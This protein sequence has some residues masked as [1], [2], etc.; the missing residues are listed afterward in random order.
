MSLVPDNQPY[1]ALV[2]GATGNVGGS[3]VQLLIQNPLCRKVILA[4]R[5][6]TNAFPSPKVSE[7]VVNMDHLEQELA[8]HANGVAVALAAFG[9]GKGSARMPVEEVR[10]IEIAYPLAFCRAAKSGGARVCALMSA[11][12]ANPKSRAT[13]ART[14]GEKEQA[15]ES[16]RFDFLGIYR[17][18]V[19][20]GNSN[21][22]GLLGAFMPLVDW[23]VPARY[24]SIHKDEIARAMVARSEQA[25]LA[26]SAGSA[27]AIPAVQVLEFKEMIGFSLSG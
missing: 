12:G 23:A 6:K 25:L 7:I 1:T 13:Y 27:P 10:K 11:A 3:I 17:P 14:L 18:S 21:T 2:L 4:N 15:A 8:P 9:V 19:I 22:P 20:L 16:V 5:R 26:L 24:H